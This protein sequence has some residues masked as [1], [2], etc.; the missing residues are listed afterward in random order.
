VKRDTPDIVSIIVAV[1]GAAGC[2][3]AGR[4]EYGASGGS[5]YVALKEAG[6][7]ASVVGL[8]V[9]LLQIASLRR[10]SAATE[11]AVK[12]TRAALVQVISASDVAKAIALIRE[13]Q[14]HLSNEAWGLARMRLQDAQELLIQFENHEAMF[15][16]EQEAEAYGK[17][18]RL[19]NVEV[20][21][22][23][24]LSEDP[25]ATAYKPR[26]LNEALVNITTTLGRFLREL[27][28]GEQP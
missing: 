17:S 22:L 15:A 20:V 28:F 13:V 27:K 8:A 2:A 19:L 14:D 3:W 1:L 4:Y 16:S 11:Q 7:L 25:E 12:E 9:A 5:L 23:L 18:L 6:G 24:E 26:K 21:N 10:T